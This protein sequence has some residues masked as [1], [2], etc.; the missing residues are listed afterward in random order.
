MKFR[1]YLH[2]QNLKSKN[3]KYMYNNDLY[4]VWL[5]ENELRF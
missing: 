2:N 4:V 5:L 1:V 3:Q